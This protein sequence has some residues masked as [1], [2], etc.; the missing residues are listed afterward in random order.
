MVTHSFNSF[1]PKNLTLY[2]VLERVTVGLSIFLPE[3]GYYEVMAMHDIQLKLVALAG[4]V[5]F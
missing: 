5:L 1:K 4:L 3:I 2:K